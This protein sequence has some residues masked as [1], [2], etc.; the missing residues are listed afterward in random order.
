MGFLRRYTS[1][2]LRGYLARCNISRGRKLW[3]ALTL[4]RLT[5]KRFTIAKFTKIRSEVLNEAEAKL[6][7]VHE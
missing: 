1:T 6:K 4:A 2:C 7:Q 3:I 5:F